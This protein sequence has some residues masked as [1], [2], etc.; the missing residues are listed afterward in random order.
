MTMSNGTQA[1]H[2][3]E[4]IAVFAFCAVFLLLLVIVSVFIPKPSLFQYNIFQTSLSLAAAG[5]GALIP[6]FLIV[7]YLNLVR[8]GGGLALF[9]LIYFINPAGF[10]ANPV[11]DAKQ[12]AT[13]P[14]TEKAADVNDED[15]TI[16]T[17][18]RDAIVDNDSKMVR[19]LIKKGADVNARYDNN[20]TPLHYVARFIEDPEI[21]RL[22]I[23]L[24]IEKG[25]D[26][27][28]KD[29]IDK[30]PLHHAI[31][32]KRSGTARFLVE[33]GAD[34][35]ARNNVGETP[36]HYA[37]AGEDPEIARFLIEEG[38]D[39]NA[40]INKESGL[41]TPLHYA[42]RFNENAKT[43]R[44]LVERGADINARRDDGAT[45]LHYAAISKN[46]E[47]SKF[48]IE[49][50]AEVD[51]KMNIGWTPLDLLS[52]ENRKMSRDDKRKVESWLRNP[53]LLR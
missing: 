23:G 35:N 8:A 6:G 3:W 24:L 17:R 37:I 19:S 7:K 45:P 16:E 31:E 44:L 40:K 33:K 29:S 43:A 42:T 27:N 1:I 39:V 12:V 9:V 53:N 13:G 2:K 20:W 15:G 32:K 21:A 26:V 34:V 22:F 30:T 36:L 10:V 18:L 50:G 41:W 52:K 14:Q 48:L 28:A 49:K 46:P 11:G 5:V 25:A 4:R 38:A 51:A 47:F